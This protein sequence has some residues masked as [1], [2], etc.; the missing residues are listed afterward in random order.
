[1]ELVGDWWTILILRDALQGLSR[2]D[3]FER[4][5][6]IA[7]NILAGRLK[8]LVQ[9]QMLERRRYSDRPVRHEYVLTSRGQDFLPVIQALLAWGNRH[10][11]PEGPSVVIA[12]QP[13]GAVADPVLVDRHTGLPLSDPAF[14][15]AAGPVAGETVRWRIEAARARKSAPAAGPLPGPRAGLNS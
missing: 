4:S 14:Q 11:A 15:I 8:L 12:H 1:M 7:P 10:L 6:G 5:L 2:F 13:T 3:E 9:E